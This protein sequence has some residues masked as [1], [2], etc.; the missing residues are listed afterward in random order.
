MKERK[1][2]R[3][4]ERREKQTFA[5]E[6]SS[7]HGPRSRPSV[8]FQIA[9][10]EVPLLSASST[11]ATV[12]LPRKSVRPISSFVIKDIFLCCKQLFAKPF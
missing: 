12:P 6:K 8:T 11:L 4:R 5:A 7:V 9:F 10:G 1:G 3:K 2:E